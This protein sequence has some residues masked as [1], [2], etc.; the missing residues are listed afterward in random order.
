MTIV[1]AAIFTSAVIMS[2]VPTPQAY[3]QGT[4]CLSVRFSSGGGAI[5]CTGQTGQEHSQLIQNCQSQVGKHSECSGSH[6]SFGAV[7]P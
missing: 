7:H 4:K 6:T 3:A 5:Q 2:A 1:T